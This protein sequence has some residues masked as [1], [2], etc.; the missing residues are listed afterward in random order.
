MS[1]LIGRTVVDVAV[2]VPAEAVANPMSEE[3]P[4]S[5]HVQLGADIV[6]AF[7]TNVAGTNRTSVRFWIG[8]VHR[9]MIQHKA[10]S[11][12]R[13]LTA[14]ISL[15]SIKDGGIKDVFVQCCWFKPVSNDY[16]ACMNYR[17]ITDVAELKA[18]AATTALYETCLNLGENNVHEL[19]SRELAIINQLFSAFPALF[20][21]AFPEPTLS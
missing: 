2:S 5:G 18:V 13:L 21:N 16:R 14:P 4:P 9:G 10:G 17:F 8:R 1:R 20:N 3:V 15:V 6:F 19:P 12:R 7:Q 11:A